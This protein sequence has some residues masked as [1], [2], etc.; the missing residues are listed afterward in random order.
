[1]IAWTTTPWTLPSNLALCVHP[2]L[3]YVRVRDKSNDKVYIMM[4]A[5]LCA[6]FKNE[7]EY[8]ILKK[9]KGSDLKGKG[10]KPLFGYFADLKK[11]GAFRVLCDTYVTEE[12]GTGVVH[13]VK[14]FLLRILTL[15]N[16]NYVETIYLA[17][18]LKNSCI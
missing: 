17:D 7:D 16:S 9:Y 8:E 1:M 11:Q 15:I 10:Y 3:S 18:F 5:R 14:F 6:L 12:S 2:E 13:Q 4:E